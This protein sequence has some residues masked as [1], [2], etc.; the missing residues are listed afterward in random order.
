MK[1]KKKIPKRYV[2]RENQKRPADCTGEK[3]GWV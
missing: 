3:M 2:S 1:K